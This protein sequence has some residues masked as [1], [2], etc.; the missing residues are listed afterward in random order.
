MLTVYQY[1][2]VEVQLSQGM[3]NNIL[4][5]S[6]HHSHIYMNYCSD[7]P[8]TKLSLAHLHG[9]ASVISEA[10]HLSKLL[11]CE[12]PGCGE[13]THPL[14]SS[15]L[16][17]NQCF[18]RRWAASE[19]AAVLAAAERLGRGRQ[20][21]DSPTTRHALKDQ[22][23]PS[24]LLGYGAPGCW[25]RHRR[26]QR[27]QVEIESLQMLEGIKKSLVMLHLQPSYIIMAWGIAR[28]LSHAERHISSFI[29]IKVIC[30]FSF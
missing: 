17:M 7:W 24:L 15:N 9:E 18:P 11:N 16:S 4:L 29:L 12:A 25:H 21:N 19:K 20:T 2:Q 5:L 1:R 3:K 23:R 22:Q 6:I 10:R 14:W 26:R 13:T 27:K 28:H 30:H 8:I